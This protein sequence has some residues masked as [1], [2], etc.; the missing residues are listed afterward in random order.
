MG[1]WLESAFLNERVFSVT[2]IIAVFDKVSYMYPRSLEPVL[3]DVSLDIRKGEFLGVIGP[4]GAGKTTLIRTLLGRL[5][6]DVKIALIFN[7]NLTLHD[8]FRTILDEFGV[9]KG[10]RTKAEF[11]TVL[12]GFLIGCLE[13]KENPVLIIDESQNLPISIL[14]EIRLLLNLETSKEKLL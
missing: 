6:D 8:L 3:R 11:L 5:G 14:E 7:P 4:S 13:R 9:K 10:F 1:T 2:A 12:N